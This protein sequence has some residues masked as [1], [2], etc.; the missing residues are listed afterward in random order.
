M[1]SLN[2]FDVTTSDVNIWFSG[3]KDVMEFLVKS[4]S[5]LPPAE[6]FQNVQCSQR[7]QYLAVVC[8][9]GESFVVSIRGKSNAVTFTGAKFHR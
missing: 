8:L 1:V 7:G 6:T 5:G 4:S 3:S 9:S 2:N